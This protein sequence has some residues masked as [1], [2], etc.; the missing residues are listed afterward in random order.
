MRKGAHDT[1]TRARIRRGGDL[2]ATETFYVFEPDGREAESMGV[3]RPD[4]IG[5][6]AAGNL[7]VA[8]YNRRSLAIVTPER[9]M[10]IAVHDPT[11]EVLDWPTNVTWAGSDRRVR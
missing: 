4:G 6:D 1:I 8:L 3:P 5:F 10:T 11:G 7:W 9:T 2:G